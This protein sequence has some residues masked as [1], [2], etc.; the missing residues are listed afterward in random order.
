MVDARFFVVW[1]DCGE[2]PTVK[3]TDAVCAETEAQRLTR[4]H[5]GKFH[6]LECYSTFEKIDIQRTYQRED[7]PPF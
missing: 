2:A 5:G 7:D 1:K 6:V 4:L 3:Y